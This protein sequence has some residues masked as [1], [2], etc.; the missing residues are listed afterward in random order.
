MSRQSKHDIAMGFLIAV[1]ILTVF[2]LCSC[3]QKPLVAPSGGAVQGGLSRVQSGANQAEVQR[4]GIIVQNQAAQS[5]EAR[6]DAKDKFLE[7][8]RQYRATHPKPSPTP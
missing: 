8:Y 6:I 4:Q 3:V 2:T 1:V 5:D 7:G